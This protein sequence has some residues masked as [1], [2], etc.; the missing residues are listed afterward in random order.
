VTKDR[1]AAPGADARAG[2]RRHRGAARVALT[3]VLALG[4][5]GVGAGWWWWQGRPAADGAALFDGRR[6]LV[7]RIQG[8][9]DRLPPAA[10]RCANCHAPSAIRQAAAG[11]GVATANFG[12][13]LD[14]ATLTQPLPRRG[15]PPSRYDAAALCRV[16]R[17]GADPALVTLPRT[18]P[19]YELA[20]ADCT[21]L[22]AYLS[23][24]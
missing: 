13:V 15:G 18:M 10:A 17:T 16:L 19:R 11:A 4:A 14:R 5:V 1:S 7:A 12:P 3:G 23:G 2:P 6:P 20:D 9:E 22:W 21:A 24:R 8:H